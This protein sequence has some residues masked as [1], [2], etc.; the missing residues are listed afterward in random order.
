MPRVPVVFAATVV[1]AF[2]WGSHDPAM[3]APPGAASLTPATLNTETPVHSVAAG[4]IGTPASAGA[5]RRP[6]PQ[7]GTA[8]WMKAYYKDPAPAGMTAAIAAFERGETDASAAFELGFIS[9]VFEQNPDQ[10]AVWLRDIDQLAFSNRKLMLQAAWLSGSPEARTF[11]AGADR[12]PLIAE[13][14][15]D[16]L[17][18][19]Q[20]AADDRMIDGAADLDYYWGRFFASGRELPV[21][22][23]MSVLPWLAEPPAANPVTDRDIAAG[24]RWT[25]AHAAQNSLA[26]NA[27]RNM[28]VLEICKAEMANA[29]SQ[30]SD[31]LEQVVAAAQL[32]PMPAR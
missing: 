31:Y 4:F 27:L 21:R 17:A 22:R 29:G 23:I 26:A 1:A 3:V 25:L 24:L 15:Y 9:A 6:E 14:G 16:P 10:V 28:R 7:P 2:L 30:A 20:V 11:L 5:L 19:R 8:A 13:L 12:E 32:P 18:Q